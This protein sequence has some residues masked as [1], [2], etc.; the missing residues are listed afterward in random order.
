MIDDSLGPIYLSIRIRF[1]RKGRYVVSSSA[2]QF[3]HSGDNLNIDVDFSWDTPGNSELKQQLEQDSDW[4][5]FQTV[6][7]T[8]D[9]ALWFYSYNNS[10]RN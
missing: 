10:A 7:R 3:I 5:Q 8:L 6:I 4:K 9:R 2:V 1:T